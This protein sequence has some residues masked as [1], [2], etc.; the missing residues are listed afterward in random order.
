MAAYVI[1]ASRQGFR[2]FRPTLNPY[3]H[4]LLAAGAAA[5]AAGFR[6]PR[7]ALA[8]A[9]V[10][11]SV[12]AALVTAQHTPFREWRY[13]ASINAPILGLIAWHEMAAR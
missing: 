1:A 5:L 7:A 9:G 11:W 2:W 3:L 6:P 13:I 8:A 12:Y 4:A 10:M